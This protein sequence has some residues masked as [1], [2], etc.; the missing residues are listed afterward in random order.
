VGIVPTFLLLLVRK[1]TG[2]WHRYQDKEDEMYSL[3]QVAKRLGVRPYRI[4]YAHTIGAIPEPK[5]FLGKRLYT[6]SDEAVIARHFNV[7]PGPEPEKGDQCV[8][9]D[10]QE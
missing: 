10:T 9:S 2:C 8:D 3:G 1:T 6:P 7:Q 4:A 5:R